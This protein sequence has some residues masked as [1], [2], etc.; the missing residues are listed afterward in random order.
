[1]GAAVIAGSGTAAAA[2]GDP[3]DPVAAPVA[4]PA[5]PETPAEAST[6]ADTGADEDGVAEEASG[7]GGE[8]ESGAL[9]A[10]PETPAAPGAGEAVLP[11][12]DGTGADSGGPGD[13]AVPAEPAGLPAP[14]A[15]TPAAG[16]DAMD[17]MG[18]AAVAKGL[19][20]AVVYALA[21]IGDAYALGGTGPHRWDCS[22][23]VQ[24]AY[25]RAGV[26]LPRIAADQ[27][28][29]TARIPRTSL[30]RGDLV[31]WSRNGR[32][33]GVH[34]VAIYLG[35]SRYLEAAR[36]GTKVRISTFARYKPNLYGRVRLP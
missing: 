35:D 28:R 15:E 33:S 29:A 12:A 14:E 1:M 34:H 20:A 10:E 16:A 36:P 21:H 23:L 4:A 24:V 17:D 27:Y 13:T 30:R 11:E 18:A 7:A 19:E 8:E 25:R 22:G 32:A 2:P 9:P 3:P 5:A 6:A 31:F 26:R